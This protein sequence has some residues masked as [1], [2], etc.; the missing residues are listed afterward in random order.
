[1]TK[2]QQVASFAPQRPAEK[3]NYYRCEECHG[4]FVTVDVHEGATPMF[5]RC[6]VS[7][8]CAGRMVSAFYRPTGQWPITVPREAMAEW[9]VPDTK[10]LGVMKRKYRALWDHVMKGGLVMR[11]AHEGTPTFPPIE[12]GGGDD[13]EV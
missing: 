13:A 12:T 11:A 7:P 3:W 4:Y 8:G 6:K 5:V 9:Y 10:E 2:R 1:M